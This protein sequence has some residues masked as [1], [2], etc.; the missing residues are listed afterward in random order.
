MKPVVVQ[1][2]MEY[3]VRPDEVDLLFGSQ[4]DF[5]TYALLEAEHDFGKVGQA[6]HWLVGEIIVEEVED[7]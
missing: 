3:V 1:C 4:K 6:N 7:E 2:T 5:N